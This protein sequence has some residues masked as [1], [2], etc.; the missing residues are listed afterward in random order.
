[1]APSGAS[2]ILDPKTDSFL[3]MDDPNVLFETWKPAEDGNGT[4]LRFLDLGGEQRTV[5][6]RLPLFHVDEAWQT[7]AVEKDEQK[8]SLSGD[9]AFSFAIHPHEIA[10]VRIA[11][12]GGCQTR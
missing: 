3:N 7:N 2:C 6:V 9:N 11:G 10:S 1:M 5:N 8:L 12:S 4:I